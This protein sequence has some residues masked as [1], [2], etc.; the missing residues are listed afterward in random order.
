MSVYG[1]DGADI[2]VNGQRVYHNPRDFDERSEANLKAGTNLCLV[3]VYRKTARWHFSMRV[4]PPDH[5]AI[6]EGT[7]L[8]LD[9]KTTHVAVPVQAMKNGK[10]IAGTLSSAKGKY[11]FINLKPGTYQVRCHVLGGYI[12][13]GG[14]QD[15]AVE[16]RRGASLQA[17]RGKTLKNI[18]F[19]IPPFKKGRWETYNY[20]FN[21][22]ADNYVYAID[23]EPDGV[24]WFGTDG[25][26][27]RYGGISRY[28]GS[29]FVNFTTKDGL[30]GNSVWSIDQD[31][32]GVLWFGTWGGVSRYDG[33][34]F[35]NFTTKDGLAHNVVIAIHR[36]PDGAMWFGTHDGGLSRYDG[37]DGPRFVNFTEKDG[38]ADNGVSSIHRDP[39]GVLWFGTGGGVSRY[40]GSEFVN[41]TTADGLASNVVYAIHRDPDAV[42]WFGTWSGVSRYDGKV[43]TNFTI[44]EGL[45]HNQVR[46]FHKGRDGA[47]WFGTWS[48][49]ISIYD[50]MAWTS[51][52]TRDGLAG[53]RVTS[54]TEDSDGSFWFGT[55]GG[56]THYRRRATPPSIRIVSVKTDQLYTDLSAI[57]PIVTGTRLTIEYNAIDFKTLPEKRQYRVRIYE[58]TNDQRPTPSSFLSLEGRGGPQARR[59]DNHP[60]SP[61]TKATSFDWT[62][63]K[64]GTYTFAVQA[65]DRDL[66][67][68]E[69]A[70]LTLKV[71]PPWYLN[72]WIAFP[73]GGAI[74]A[75]LIWA[76]VF[77]LRYYA[78][79]RRM[80]EQERR[81]REALEAKNS[82]LEIAR[83]AAES[84]NRAKSTFLANMS[85]E[86][87]TPMNAIL[88]YAQFLQRHTIYGSSGY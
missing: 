8:M 5:D 85:H 18:D 56:I 71:V 43:F 37:K 49:G 57:P 16:T 47:M 66:N 19:R 22:L 72:G 50:G 87:R 17:E 30:A 53:N 15:T 9:D 81:S 83:D 10:I 76:I 31:S 33:S 32:D 14:K 84:A 74:L 40:D 78:Q 6:I 86:I 58:P 52:D 35:V 7:L 34:E 38:L 59:G 55:D 51:L 88:G 73:S 36:D 20:L 28:D 46:A 13:Y 25:G 60:Y 75:L 82:E 12:Y 80:L 23:Q 67:Y 70:T 1:R 24:L 2:W 11:R 39:D 68:S 54:I 64:P 42:M 29:E 62:P 61:P 77:S 26:V 65:I 4:F 69:P 21:G 48:G 63:K 44:K 41:F 27:S 79:R 3:K 45:A